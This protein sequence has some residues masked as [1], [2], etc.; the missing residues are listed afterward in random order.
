MKYFRLVSIIAMALST[1][2][3]L[4]KLT[5]EDATCVLATYV[6]SCGSSVT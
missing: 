4:F 2:R 6:N 5:E 1:F 3:D